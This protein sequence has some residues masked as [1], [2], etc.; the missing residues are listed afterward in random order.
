MSGNKSSKAAVET[1]KPIAVVPTAK[2]IV[3]STKSVETSFEASKAAAKSA[4]KDVARKVKKVANTVHLKQHTY[5][6]NL[7][8]LDHY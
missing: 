7:V 5:F 6:S 3:A 8:S 2:P 4:G 1:S